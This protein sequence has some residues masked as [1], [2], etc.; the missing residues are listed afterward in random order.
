MGHDVT[1][2]PGDSP[3]ALAACRRIL[4]ASGVDLRWHEHATE[5]G[6][7]TEALLDS[8]NRTLA[9]LMGHQVGRRDKGEPAPIVHLR[10]ALGVFANL[11]PVHGVEGIPTRFPDTDLVV[12]RETTED[13]YASLEHESIPGTFES[14]K[15]TTRGGCERIARYAFDTARRLGRRKVTI[16]HK[17]NIMKRSDGLFLSVAREIARE[18][19]D[20]ETE[21]CIVDAL[22]MKLVRDP[23][24]FDVLV[25]GNLFGDIVADLCAGLV[26]GRCN[27]P[28]INVGR[29]GGRLFTTGHGDLPE[30][31]GTEHANPASLCF[32]GVLLL[33][34]LGEHDAADRVMRALS[35][36]L[37]AGIK[38]RALGGSA[39]AA[40]Y[41]DAVIARL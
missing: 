18:Y 31:R 36:T 34:H 20:I 33:R 27:A 17:A 9:V 29:E 16:V 7:P 11:R 41:A 1:L 15:V 37:A 28:S 25:C 30:D 14:L 13:I 35:S 5:E 2:V 40:E 22:C 38:A 6:R 21:D 39:T 19:P 26:G 32:S 4:D 8:A 10:R 24:Q 23:T 12:V 3:A